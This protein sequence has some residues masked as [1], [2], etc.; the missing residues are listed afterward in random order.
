M[1]ALL[2]L[3]TSVLADPGIRIEGR[4]TTRVEVPVATRAGT[5]VAVERFGRYSIRTTSKH[6]VQLQLIDRRAGPRDRSGSAGSQDGRIDVFLD[7]G[8]YKIITEGHGGATGTA[9]LDMLPFDEVNGPKPPQIV[10]FKPIDERL[11]DLQKRSYWLHVP[12]QKTVVIEAAGR[13]LSDLRLWKDG[14][15]LLAEPPNHAETTPKVGRPLHVRRISQTLDAGLYLLVAYGGPPAKWADDDGTHPFHLRYGIRPLAA[16]SR[17]H[18]TVGPFGYD[19][20]LVPHPANHFRVEL[21]EAKPVELRVSEFEATRA[22]NEGGARGAITKKTMPPTT[23]VNSNARNG[24]FSIVTIRADAGQPYVLQHFDAH[25]YSWNQSGPTWIST[26]HSGTAEDSIDATGFVTRHGRRGDRNPVDAYARDVVELSKRSAWSRRFNA[27]EQTTMFIDVREPGKYVLEFSGALAKF[28]VEPYF[29]STPKDYKQP[30]F[31]R[32]TREFELDQRLY[33]LTIAPINKGI[34]QVGLRHRSGGRTQEHVQPNL[35]FERLNLDGSGH[36]T[37]HMNR[38]PGVMTGVVVR[39]LPI[40]LTEGLPLALRPSER[41]RFEATAS[42]A[43][44]V[45]VLDEQGKSQAFL[46]D[47]KRTT[48]AARV[49]SGRHEIEVEGNGKVIAQLAVVFEPRR[50]SPDVPLPPLPDAVLAGLPNFERL[51]NNTPLR[52]DLERNASATFLVSAS[53]EALYRLES[54]GLLETQGELRTRT[55]PNLVSAKTNGVGRNFLIQQFVGPGDYQLGVSTL[56]RS[57]GHL[58]LRL[59]R[60]PFAD[61]GVLTDG[62]TARTTLAAGQ[63][64]VYRFRIEE[65][66]RYRLRSIGVDRT[67]NIR[68][69]DVDGWPIVSPNRRGDLTRHFDKGSYRWVVLPGSVDLRVVTRMTRV[70]SSPKFAGHGPHALPLDTTARHEWR[71]SSKDSVRAPDR[72]QFELGGPSDVTISLSNEMRADLVSMDSN[73]VVATVP[74]F[75][76]FSGKLGAGRY[77]IRAVH[78]RRNDRVDYT[79]LV[80]PVSLVPGL[81]RSY[82]APTTIQL[83]VGRTGLIE[84]ASYGSEDLRAELID[85]KGELIAANDDRIDDWNFHVARQLEPGP[86]TLRLV[87]VGRRRASVAVTM[88]APTRKDLPALTLPFAGLVDPAG[89]MHVYPIEVGPKAEILVVGARSKE[90]IGLA[91]EETTASGP[92]IIDSATGRTASIELPIGNQRKLALRVW[93]IDRRNQPLELTAAAIAVSGH[94]ERD[95]TKGVYVTKVAGIEPPVVATRIALQSSGVFE[96]PDGATGVRACSAGGEACDSVSRLATAPSV[97]LW[98]VRRLP[99]DKTQ[100]LIKAK[101]LVIPSSGNR[102]TGIELIAGRPAV[103][104][105]AAGGKGPIVARIDGIIGQPRLHFEDADRPDL[106]SAVGDKS[107]VTVSINPSRNAV[108]AHGQGQARLSVR[109]FDNPTSSPGALGTSEIAVKGGGAHRI[110]L[111]AGA[112]QLRLSLEHGAI[113]AIETAGVVTSVH[114]AKDASLDESLESSADSLLV[115]N[116]DIRERRVAIEAIPIE[117]PLALTASAPFERVFTRAGAV[118]LDVPPGQ[119]SPLRIVGA[120]SG[121]VLI[122]RDGTVSRGDTHDAHLG[123]ALTIPHGAS[124]VLAWFDGADAFV[125]AAV[126]TTVSLSSDRP[127]YVALEGAGARVAIDLERRALVHLRAPTP[128]IVTAPGV[129]ASRVDI[130]ANGVDVMRVLPAGRSEISLRA[131]AGAP[132]YGRAEFVAHDLTALEEGLGPEVLVPSGSVRAFAFSTAKKGNVGVGVSAESDVVQSV[133]YTVD[134]TE[135]GR[136]LLQLHDL[137]AGAYVL[138]L[139]V[140]ANGAPVRARPVIVGVADPGVGPPNERIRHYIDLAKREAQR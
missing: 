19:R 80:K 55:I 102:P 58:G 64:V 26:V 79:L 42:E 30:P 129:A 45:L 11:D 95:L 18:F 114:W 113:V 59:E 44:R 32:S 99:S 133:L 135:L 136:G 38:Q 111:P 89:E 28:R 37:L 118:H 86:Y 72:W 36:Y 2:F 90:T 84:L 68:L 10:E 140:A 60:S 53:E 14:L 119:T 35:R 7:R 1:T 43:G 12:Q 123:G 5:V 82:S 57:R 87:P 74:P 105:F 94:S 17:R 137:D 25:S 62:T 52:F 47:G 139:R 73:A 128:A 46:L 39:S 93:S 104:D 23:S 92:R 138:V 34:V 4:A 100:G 66:A 101:R 49:D 83:A 134:G 88:S 6:G 116:P 110:A 8:E 31:V 130:E 76:G 29:S 21:H 54:T 77:E 16:A 127:R 121:A 122:G 109:R 13:N 108:R 120:T 91:I 85:E 132:L 51:T 125:A 81:T 67:F 33:V 15:W 24:G 115:L 131:M 124:T 3:S 65:A 78:A 22:F 27:L 70:A 106:A 61:G 117:R 126:P 40:D 96:L 107:M 112:K 48:G 63:G 9:R 71:E 56:G 50:L 97:A 75:R 98:L 20:W 103:V 41:V 69:E